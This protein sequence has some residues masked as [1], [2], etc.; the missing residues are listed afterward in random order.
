MGRTRLAVVAAAALSLLASCSSQV[1]GSAAAPGT[2][3]VTMTPAE[4]PDSASDTPSTHQV[5]PGG[6]VSGE[7][8]PGMGEANCLGCAPVIITGIVSGEASGSNAISD[9]VATAVMNLMLTQIR[10]FWNNTYREVFN[11][12]TQ[13]DLLVALTTDDQSFACGTQVVTGTYSP[14]YC[15]LN[16]TLAAPIQV[17]K[18]AATKGLVRTKG[19]TVDPAGAIGVFFLL[20]HEW[21]HNVSSELVATFG[22]LETLRKVPDVEQ[23]NL[24]DCAAGMAIAGVEMKFDQADAAAVLKFAEQAGEDVGRTHGTPEQRRAAV[25]MGLNH[26]RGDWK[27]FSAGLGQCVSTQAPTLKQ[28]MHG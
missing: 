14:G 23:E 13:S 6:T 25:S 12:S 4:T 16:D 26:A 24:A 1:A 7:Q 5:S 27:G 11:A 22:G 20:A 8:L 19:A 10:D 17:T 9:D 28:L 2:G 21:G 18:D 3:I 15:F